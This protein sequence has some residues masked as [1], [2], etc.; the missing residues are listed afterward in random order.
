[1]LSGVHLPVGN[2]L[3]IW[4]LVHGEG[5]FSDRVVWKSALNLSVYTVDFSELVIC[6]RLWF[7]PAR[8]INLVGILAVGF[9]RIS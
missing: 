9:L 1:M 3:L 6:R 8:K 2:P 7:Y 4:V 5:I